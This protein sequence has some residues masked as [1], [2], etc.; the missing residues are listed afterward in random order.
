MVKLELTHK[1]FID[2][3]RSEGKSEATVVAYSKDIEQIISFLKE[4]GV[5]NVEGMTIEYLAG[6]MESLVEK[7]YTPKSIS[8]KTNAARTFIKFLTKEGYLREDISSQLKHP[9]FETK[10]PRILT[11]L[12]YRA[13]RDAARGD[14]RSYAMIEVLLQ[15]GLTISEL[16]GIRLEHMDIKGETGTLFVPKKNNRDERTVP[17]NKAVVEAIK[18]Y[19]ETGRPD[20][21]G[22]STS[23]F[24]TKTGRPLLI[25]NIRST[26]DRFFRIAGVEGAKVNDLRHTFVAH[27]LENGVNISY[28]A[29]VS[30]HKRESTTEKYLEYINKPEKM[31][32]TELGVL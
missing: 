31:D 17:L 16:A 19:I 22:S 3:L 8:R 5:E 7:N 4:K 20:V 13:L 29:R 26:I 27:H 15:A 9:K 25:R 32:K 2:K 30:G 11:K 23:L 28:L 1:K 24:I 14:N 6:F 18:K 21:E 10:A 12:E